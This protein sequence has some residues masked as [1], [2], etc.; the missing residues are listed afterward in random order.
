MRAVIDT[1][2]LVSGF[3]SR[4]SHPAEVLDAWILGRFTPVVSPELVKE[5]VAVL[6]RDKFVIL[7]SV[8]DRINLLEKILALPWVAMVYPRERVSMV[9][10]DP[11]DDKVLEC[12]I[13]GKAKWVVTGNKH[14][15]EL[16]CM[17]DIAIIT[18]GEFVR[19][20]EGTNT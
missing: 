1:S 17:K 19:I 11:Q 12:A 16:P 6:T 2:V 13:E 9:S 7:G 14:L 5:Y 15:L 3:L 18:A 8:T 10:K 4:R 20:L